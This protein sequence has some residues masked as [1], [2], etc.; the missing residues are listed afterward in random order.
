MSFDEN[1]LV[2]PLDKL[3]MHMTCNKF[4]KFG[5]FTSRGNISIKDFFDN[6]K[7]SDFSPI[8]VGTP[9]GDIIDTSIRSGKI[10][11]GTGDYTDIPT[12]HLNYIK[13]VN[14]YY[15]GM[16]MNYDNNIPGTKIERAIIPFITKVITPSIEDC[17]GKF[18]KYEV[19][20]HF[21]TFHYDTFINYKQKGTVLIFPPNTINKFTGG[22]LVFKD[23]SNQELIIKPADFTVWTAVIFGKILHKCTPITSGVR[24][25]LKYNLYAYLPG[26]L[27][28]KSSLNKEDIQKLIDNYDKKNILSV[29]SKELD[30]VKMR[31]SELFKERQ[32]I[33]TEY[34]NEM[35]KKIETHEVYYTD[36]FNLEEENKNQD[37]YYLVKNFKDT[38]YNIIYNPALD[39]IN[40]K[41]NMVMLEHK[42]INKKINIINYESSDNYKD[43]LKNIYD[44]LKTVGIPIIY[45][46]ETFYNSI[47]EYSLKHLKIINELL[48]KDISVFEIN[49]TFVKTDYYNSRHGEI[50]DDYD[51]NFTKYDGDCS[52]YTWINKNFEYGK[53]NSKYSEYNDESGDDIITKYE[54]SCLIIYK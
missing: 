3:N 21:D 54:V 26:V 13:I 14:N 49:K 5:N 28:G 53:V 43:D 29:V 16:V 36:D 46:M 8:T 40:H 2:I 6:L 34:F 44:K 15:Y 42:Y 25:V 30:T 10:Y 17:K 52:N 45:C 37:S 38:N 12:S 33:E 18:M 9:K 47:N 20:D 50:K 27:D 35:I 41:L 19:G 4:E 39:T 11:N 23:D 1:L 32:K 7:D 31:I 22:E 48:S 24:Y 51:Y